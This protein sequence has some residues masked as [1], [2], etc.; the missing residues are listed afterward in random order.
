MYQGEENLSLYAWCNITLIA[1]LT[2]VA[3]WGQ[4]LF[5]AAFEFPTKNIEVARY[6]P[7]A[8]LSMEVCKIS[9]E[10]VLSIFSKKVPKPLTKC[11]RFEFNKINVLWNGH[12]IQ[13]NQK[14]QWGRCQKVI[15]L[16]KKF[17]G[18]FRKHQLNGRFRQILVAFVGLQNFKSKM[19]QMQLQNDYD[20]IVNIGGFCPDNDRSR[21]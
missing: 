14:W 10:I 18:L 15:G 11:T 4:N 1:C 13:K 17:C 6:F 5:K 16:F 21:T 3:H 2:S 20:P 12:K 7:T 8:L 9:S 19:I